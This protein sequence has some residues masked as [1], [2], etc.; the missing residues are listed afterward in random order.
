[1]FTSLWRTVIV[2]GAVPRQWQRSTIVLVDKSASETR[3]IALLSV[4]WRAGARAVVQRLRP[5]V[6]QWMGH[7]AVGGAPGRS[8]VNFHKRIF[9]AWMA[10]TTTYVQQDLHAFF[11]SLSSVV[12][13]DAL[14]KLGAPARL[15][16]LVQVFYA[17]QERLFT[18]EGLT[19]SK[20]V[21]AQVG[22]LQ[23]CP[24]SPLLSLGLGM[25]WAEYVAAPHIECGILRPLHVVAGQPRH[26]RSGGKCP[27][28]KRHL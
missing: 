27:Y 2:A 24:F 25:L 5:W 17:R 23:G 10:G 14:R 13:C 21:P 22:I 6:M 1:M 8:A 18:V 28:P 16:S 9:D 15:V 26:S 20:W 12:V 3:P 7:R 4:A 19:A 11:D